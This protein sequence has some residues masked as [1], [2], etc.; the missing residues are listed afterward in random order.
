MRSPRRRF[1]RCRPRGR[2]GQDLSFSPRR[3]SVRQYQSQN[4]TDLAVQI[5]RQILRKGPSANYNPRRGEDETDHAR[6]QAVGVLARSGKL[7]ELIE[8]A[9]AQLKASPKSVPMHQALVG[10]YQAAGDKD[11]LK[12]TLRAMADLQNRERQ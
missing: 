4:Q 1:P 3:A 6:N 12:A 2:A 11:K 8:R 10:Y 5:A 9:E 7:K